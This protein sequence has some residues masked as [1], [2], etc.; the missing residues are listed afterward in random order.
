MEKDKH[1]DQPTAFAIVVDGDNK[2]WS[3]HLT[4]KI[5]TVIENEEKWWQIIEQPYFSDLGEK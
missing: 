5:S 3:V 1:V 4:R 2:H